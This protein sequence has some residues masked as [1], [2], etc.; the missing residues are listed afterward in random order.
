MF[1]FSQ[2]LFLFV[3]YTEINNKENPHLSIFLSYKDSLFI[4]HCSHTAG[5]HTVHIDG[6]S[7]YAVISQLF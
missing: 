3:I 5:F 6:F 7:I 1:K 2:M 4:Y